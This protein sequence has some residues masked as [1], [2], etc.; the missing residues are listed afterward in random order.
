MGAKIRKM[1]GK[2]KTCC[3]C[4]PEQTNKS[5]FVDCL[6]S[7]VEWLFLPESAAQFDCNAEFQNNMCE[8]TEIAND[9]RN[10]KNQLIEKIKST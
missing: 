9:T 4:L 10:I 8:G 5:I 1:G 3:Y 7:R 6:E 2:V